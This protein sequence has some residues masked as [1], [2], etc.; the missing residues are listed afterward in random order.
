VQGDEASLHHD[1]GLKKVTIASMSGVLKFNTFMMK[2]FVQG[3]RATMLID[4]G[5]SH[6]F[7]DMPMVER[8]YI[9]TIDFEGLL[10]EVA[11]RITMAC[12]RYIPHMSLTLGRYTL[13]R[14]FYVLL[15]S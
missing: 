4:G 9:P 1:S 7:I 13:T 6:N 12:D 10:V 8:R 2:G 11:G 15:A 14:Y 3:Q 5:A